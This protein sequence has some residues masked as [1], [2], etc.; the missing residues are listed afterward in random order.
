MG[1]A[2]VSFYQAFFTK[3]TNAE[4]SPTEEVEMQQ[5]HLMSEA[6]PDV[7]ETPMQRALRNQIIG[8]KAA[9]RPL[10]HQV[11]A[12]GWIGWLYTAIY[13]PTVQA[14][15]IAENWTNASGALKLVRALGISIAALSL[16]IDTK[17]RYA[18]KLKNTK[19]IGSLGYI[20]FNLINAGSA[21]GMGIMCAALLIKGAIDLSIKL[22]FII[23][24][25]IFLVIW[26]VASFRICPVRDGGIQGKGIFIDVLVGAFAGLFLAFPAFIVL[27]TGGEGPT[28]TPNGFVYPES[29]EASLQQ[30]LS[31][32]S[33]AAWQKFVAIFP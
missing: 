3:N 7:N 9:K 26:A 8:G 4:Q 24:Y 23:P 30:Y 20:A 19:Y 11:T 16:T 17:R 27:Q 32:D 21:L 18:T 5:Q 10:T 29:G 6:P 12:F 13:S 2:F 14:L 22:Y 25:C 1:G 28:L 15:W 33:V 31:C